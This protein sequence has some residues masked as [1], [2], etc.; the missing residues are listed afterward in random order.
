MLVL[1]LLAQSC[2]RFYLYS[3][4]ETPFY[5]EVLHTIAD[6]MMCC[7][8]AAL[9]M[10]ISVSDTVDDQKLSK[11]DNYAY[12]ILIA[13]ALFKNQLLQTNHSEVLDAAAYCDSL[14]EKHSRNADVLFL[15]SRAHYYKAVGETENDD[16]KNAC[17]D[18]LISLKTIDAIKS[19]NRDYAIDYF[20]GLIYNRLAN[21]YYD[22]TNDIALRLY[23]KA[24]E[25]FIKCQADL[26]LAYNYNSIAK[27]LSSDNRY[28]ESEQYL[29]MADSLIN[30][31][32]VIDN[33]AIAKLKEG[34]LM[35]RA[36]NLSEAENKYDEALS[37]M[38]KLYNNSNNFNTKIKRS[39]V[40][41]EMYYQNN[42]IDS[43]LYYYEIA[44]N[45]DHPAKITVASR[46]V[47]IG[48]TTNNNDLI[49]CY[50]PYLA[51]ETNKELEF[52]PLKSELIAMY[53]QF[54]SDKHKEEN[55]NLWLNIITIL[56]VLIIT[57]VAVFYIVSIVREKKHVSEINRKDWYIGT[58]HG[59]IKKTN[60]ENKK[61]KESIKSFEDKLDVLM[62]VKTSTPVSYAERMQNVK[63]HELCKKL[64]AVTQMHIKTTLQYPELSLTDD[65]KL[66]IVE[67]FDKEFDGS[68]H[69]IINK[70]SRLKQS[71]EIILCLT[72]LGFDN[73][74]MAAVLGSSY[75]NVFVRSQK[76]LE[77]LGGGEDLQA[78]IV[79]IV[80]KN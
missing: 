79:A 3:E 58:L 54:E 24:N 74:H 22:F 41:A 55:I 42:M 44:F 69:A 76:C 40:L 53:E 57:L 60:A 17:K 16:V 15:K 62:E 18:Y 56:I 71:D 34:I 64:M 31:N 4:K 12:Q 63:N 48:R 10:L 46:I 78:V 36:I 1:S 27:I 25:C 47:D 61:A 51:D 32:K 20:N 29:M 50:A 49:A 35:T 30:I 21:I 45:N 80:N 28:D 13:E 7:P 37:I 43:A 52:T 23:Y 33:E 5:I 68:V 59:K 72:L 9:D 19:K 73:K 75:H 67:I 8:D 38:I 14:A 77:I 26:S 2:K 11:T 70:Y 66:Q 39:A 65:E 6:T